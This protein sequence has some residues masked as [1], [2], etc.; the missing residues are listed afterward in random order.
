MPTPKSNQ[1]VAVHY[2]AE[3]KGPI[4]GY[5]V[6]HLK[7]NYWRVAR[8]H[9]RDDVMQEAFLVFLRV[10][11]KYPELETPQHFMALFKTAWGNHFTD[12][13]NDDT[14]SRVLVDAPRVAFDDGE[15]VEYDM[16][17]DCDND[18]L[19]AVMLAEAPKEVSM[20][21]NLF[22]NAPQELLDVALGSWRGADR[23]CKAGGSKRINKMLGLPPDLDVMQLVNDYLRRT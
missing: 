22:L 5:V 18:G 14:Q 17:G 20:V 13:A 1:G 12:M 15:S 10:K 2:L 23:R 6:N 9:E 8:L 11:V 19:L 16:P 7:K 4:E 3:F 21:L